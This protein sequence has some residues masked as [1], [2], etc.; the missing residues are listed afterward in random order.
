V[1]APYFE[2]PGLAIL[3]IANRQY[4]DINDFHWV[5]LGAVA[6]TFALFAF[7]GRRWVV[8]VTALAVGAWLLT[9]EIYVTKTNSD[10]SRIF[11]SRLPAPRNWVDQATGS[12]HVTFLG[13]AL[14]LDPTPLWL[15]E[16]WNRSIDHVEAIDGTAPGPG[17]A[18]GPG[19]ESPDGALRDY[20][21][22][23][24]TLAGP[25]VRLAA[26]ILEQR[27]G[28][29]L[30]RTPTRWHLLDEQQNVFADGWAT[31]P[32]GYTYFPRAGPGTLNV[33]LSRTAFTGKGPPGRATIRVGTVKVNDEGAP[34]F[35][36]TLVV[37]HAVVRNGGRTVVRIHVPS[38]PV[39]VQVNMTTFRAP[40]DTRALAAQ[41]GFTFSPDGT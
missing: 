39:T 13:Q 24:Y 12:A 3:T 37:R 19:L 29:T 26:P 30:Y 22:D 4:W 33:D 31:S 16:F 7:R 11:A 10:Y 34:V 23:P 20:T 18:A 21:G 15:A 5:E 9:G 38:T 41:P 28:L 35:G 40:P 27:D 14:N 8:G 2:A 6:A 25:G 32:I 17:P 36:R 1:G